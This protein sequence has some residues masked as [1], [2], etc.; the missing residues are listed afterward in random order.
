MGYLW[1]YSSRNYTEYFS[2]NCKGCALP[3]M[4]IK[5][6]VSPRLTSERKQQGRIKT[7]RGC[8]GRGEKCLVCNSSWLHRAARIVQPMWSNLFC[9]KPKKV[10]CDRPVSRQTARGSALCSPCSSPSISPHPQRTCTGDDEITAPI[11]P[12]FTPSSR[13]IQTRA[14]TP[15]CTAA[16]KQ[17]DGEEKKVIFPE[18]KQVF[19]HILL[20]GRAAEARGQHR[21]GSCACGLLRRRKIITFVLK[22]PGKSEVYQYQRDAEGSF[23]SWAGCSADPSFDG[24]CS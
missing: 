15:P 20:L 8:W 12:F 1:K 5:Q 10:A 21:C 9:G 2:L 22:C 11:V 18:V 19:A 14:S 13:N 6:T 3:H 24:V 16:A 7:T 17:K 23:P 4:V